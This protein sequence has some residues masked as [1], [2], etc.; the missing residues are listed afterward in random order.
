MLEFFFSEDHFTHTLAAL[1][2]VSR[3]GDIGS[4]LLATPTLALEANP[5]ARRFKKST[6][7][8]GLGL[9]FFPYV[10]LGYRCAQHVLHT[11]YLSPSRP[12]DSAGSGL[13]APALGSRRP[14]AVLSPQEPIP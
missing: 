2:L 7:M 10:R 12:A 4:T 6:L 1:V 5:M 3:L 8:L 13:S 9:A 14:S 11:S